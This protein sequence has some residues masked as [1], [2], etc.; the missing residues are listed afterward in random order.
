LPL[1][2]LA[3]MVIAIIGVVMVVRPSTT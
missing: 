1:L 2:G 3:G